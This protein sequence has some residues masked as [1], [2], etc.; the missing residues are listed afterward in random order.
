[1]KFP[2]SIAEMRRTGAINAS[3]LHFMDFKNDPHY[4]W[5]GTGDLKTLDGKVWR[6]IGEV[7]TM[8]GGGQQVGLIANNMT[9]TMAGNSDLLTDDLVSKTLDGANQIYGQRYFAAVQF[10]DENWQPTDNYRVFYV[11]VMD[12]MTYKKNADQRL[13]TL[14]IESV[15][16]RRRAPRLEMFTDRSQK[17]DYPT[18]RGLEFVSALKTRTVLFPKY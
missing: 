17:N 6:G 18:D 12:K 16:V 15:F 4:A 13:I 7:V 11:G 5:M 3:I 9:L 1:L 8:Q 14:N 2:D 10:F